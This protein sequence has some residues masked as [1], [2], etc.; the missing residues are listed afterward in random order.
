MNAELTP[1]ERRLRWALAVLGVI[2]V[3]S[4]VLYLARGWTGKAD[5]AFVAN[6]VTKD[7]FFLTFAGLAIVNVRRFGWLTALVIIGHVLLAC[8]LLSMLIAHKTGGLTQVEPFLGLGKT[9]FAWVWLLFD[10]LIALWLTGLYT[11]ARR[12]RQPLQYVW[13]IHLQTLKALGEVLIPDES[14]RLTPDRIAHNVDMYLSKFS[15]KG[16]WKVLVGLSLLAP[17]ALPTPEAGRRLVQKLTKGESR[18]WRA[19]GWLVQPFIGVGS[20]AVYFGYYGDEASYQ[21]IGYR[22]FSMRPQFAQKMARVDK[23]R[24]RVVSIDPDS[25]GADELQ[26]DYVI[27]GSGAAGAVLAYELAARE[28][29][30]LVLERGKHVDPSAFNDVET[31]M[32]SDLYSDGAIQ[33]SRDLR[34][35]VL[36]GMCVGGSTVVNN[37]VC[38]EAPDSVL[39]RWNDPQGLNAGLDRDRLN[40]S[41]SRIE[42]W[43]R[44]R[45]QAE[46]VYAGGARKF[47]AGAKEL[48]IQDD[49]DVVEANIVDCLGCGYCNIGCKFG[50][51]LSMLDTVLPWAQEKFKDRVRILPMCFVKRIEMDGPKATGV[52]CTLGKE[53]RRIR[54]RAREG[55]IVSAGAINSSL[56]LR[57]SRIR[58]SVAGKG[59]AFNMA[60]PLTAHFNEKL[61]SYD[62]LQISHYLTPPEDEGYVIETWFNPP[63]MQSLFMPGWSMDHYRNMDQYDQMACAGVVVGTAS[64]GNV[65]FG[66]FGFEPRQEDLRNLMT[67]VKQ[68][69][70]IFLAAGATRVMP[71]TYRYTSFK[72]GDDLHPLFDYV[73]NR[74]GISLNSAHPQGGNAISAFADRG[75]VDPSFKVHGLANVYVCDASVF[76]SSITVNPQYTVMALAHYAATEISGEELLWVPDPREAR[77]GTPP[78]PTPERTGVPD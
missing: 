30:V 14:R 23:V 55:V 59:L 37:A 8:L 42:S 15:A 63:A 41:F 19:L 40:D 45:K 18:L 71:S 74:T 77:F 35:A 52:L 46:K 11:A 10:L 49:V 70:E 21:S 24:P 50:K 76:P 69:A 26:A 4:I 20:Q 73:K 65:R 68:L 48:H 7:G 31:N 53:K 12:S 47:L 51:K 38:I 5:Y 60:T 64:N 17:F 54:V 44:V 43:L 6:S 16:K 33:I 27:V 58:L 67:G 36:Q 29:S 72:K 62:G 2:F 34:F 1:Q 66:G 56:L 25:V 75:V 32:L 28:R 3:A 61:D 22:R 57:R 9:E 39:D 13:P 78:V